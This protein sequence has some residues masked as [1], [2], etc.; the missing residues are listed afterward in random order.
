MASPPSNDKIVIVGQV[1][2]RSILSHILTSL[3]RGH[4]WARCRHC[5]RRERLWAPHNRGGRTLA[6]GHLVDLHIPIVSRRLAA[7][8]RHRA[9]ARFA[10]ELRSAGCNF[11]AISGSDANALRW[12]RLGYS[13]LCKLASQDPAETFVQR[14]PST[15][16][17]DEDIP[18]HKMQTM[19]EYLEDV[20]PLLQKLYV[21]R[22]SQQLTRLSLGSSPG[23]SYQR[24]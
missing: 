6:R 21:T 10:N 19:S 16:L 24:V 4:R 11:S 20:S 17:W 8:A 7:Q 14:T 15:E 18:H 23:M 3:Q 2:S 1:I 13:H 12:D 5:P 22:P 9:S